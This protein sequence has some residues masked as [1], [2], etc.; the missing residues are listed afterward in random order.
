MANDKDGTSDTKTTN[1]KP[2][3]IPLDFEDALEA[4]LQVPP[5]ASSNGN[6]SHSKKKK[7]PAKASD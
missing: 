4:L 6:G 3:H 5:K 1:E 2:V 7:K